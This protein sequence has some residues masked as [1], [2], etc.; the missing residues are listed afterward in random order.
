M[1]R[2]P[3]DA[4]TDANRALAVA[5]AAL[6]L[7]IVIAVGVTERNG[8]SAD[9][10]NTRLSVS[11]LPAGTEPPRQSP[12]TRDSSKKTRARDTTPT[13]LREVALGN[14][15]L[16]AF[17]GRPAAA[18]PTFPVITLP[19]FP[20]PETTTVPPTTVPS[21][22]V[23]TTTVPTVT[24]PPPSPTATTAPPVTPP[25][26]IATPGPPTAT[27]TTL[28][29]KRVAPTATPTLPAKG[30]APTV[31]STMKPGVRAPIPRRSVGSLAVAR[32]C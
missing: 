8:R 12:P 31:T 25:P 2:K 30:V 29:S 16:A 6:M 24:V 21:T 10:P 26:I 27:P 32:A 20:P 15:C 18:D 1:T 28:P 3:V 9:A 11:P 22:T 13:T 19:T 14:A 7:L 5:L 4:A 23:P 17:Q